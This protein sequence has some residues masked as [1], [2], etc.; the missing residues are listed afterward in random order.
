MLYSYSNIY[1][2]S[3]FRKFVILSTKP[4]QPYRKN[5]LFIFFNTI[6]M[7]L[8]LLYT[9]L[10]IKNNKENSFSIILLYSLFYFLS[11]VI[12]T[13]YCN[14]LIQLITK[15]KKKSEMESSSNSLIQ[16]YREHNKEEQNNNSI[17][18]TVLSF[19]DIFNNN[20]MFY[21]MRRKQIKPL[22]KINMICALSEFLLMFS[23]LLIPY[24]NFKQDH[25][26][27]IPTSLLGYILF[28]LYLVHY[29][30]YY[31]LHF[32]CFLV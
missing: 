6:S 22:Y 32:Y 19:N 4:K 14:L 13:F 8:F 2:N 31:Y 7:S 28:Y 24:D 27:I 10:L 29:H 26:K 16:I 15:L 21:S 5:G 18:I 11:T 17:S 9:M 3:F 23:I 12:L 30:Y 1:N 25:Y 20:E